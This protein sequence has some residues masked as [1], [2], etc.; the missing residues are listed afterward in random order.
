M[1]TSSDMNGDAGALLHL[2][3]MASGEVYA[4]RTSSVREIIELGD[5]TNVPMTPK[6]MR[7]AINLRGAAIPLLDLAARFG[8]APLEIS[9]RTCIVVVEVAAGG[10]SQ[11]IGIMVDTVNAVIEIAG[12]DITAIPALELQKN[13]RQDTRFLHG[14]GTVNGKF[15]VII[16]VDKLV[17]SEETGIAETSAIE[18]AGLRATDM[19]GAGHPV[20][21]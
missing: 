11:V 14:M 13:A 16:D 19:S 6:Y 7:G 21:A 15:V 10:A 20:H 17:A 9:R 5:V 3:V 4:M 18:L 12:S 2:T 8:K 1:N